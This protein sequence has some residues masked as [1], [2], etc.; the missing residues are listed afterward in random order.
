MILGAGRWGAHA[1]P[2]PA[3]TPSPESPR[4]ESSPGASRLDPMG[5]LALGSGKEPILI[6][7]DQL[8]FDWQNNKVVYRGKVHATQG[9]LVIDCDTLTINFLR[10]ESKA[11]KAGA[12]PAKASAPDRKQALPT[13][14]DPKQGGAGPRSPTLRDI[15]A[16]GHVVITQKG[17]RATGGIAVFSQQLRQLVLGG[18]PVLRDGPNEVTGDRIVVYVDEGR[19][20]VESSGSKRVSAVLYPGSAKGLDPDGKPVAKAASGGAP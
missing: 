4:G 19:S 15:V 20:V 12:S 17:R 8:D 13:A 7:A 14:S 11:E 1:E 6:S 18:D 9:D 16:E 2:A 5:Q 10:P 3:A